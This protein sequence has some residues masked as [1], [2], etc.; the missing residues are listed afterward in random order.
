MTETQVS[1]IS[2]GASPL[3]ELE[4]PFTVPVG[5]ARLTLGELLA[6]EAG[7]TVTLDGGADGPVAIVVNGLSVATGKLVLVDGDF[8][9]RI[10]AVEAGAGQKVLD[11]QE[12]GAEPVAASDATA[13]PP[14]EVITSRKLE[15]S[16]RLTQSSTLLVGTQL[17]IRSATR[18]SPQRSRIDA[19]CRSP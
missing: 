8:A 19:T 6:L 12:A 9:V 7:S 1:T 10:E 5:S 17:R 3:D 13:Q 4:L 2:D 15:R 11:R 14:Q 16:S 18:G